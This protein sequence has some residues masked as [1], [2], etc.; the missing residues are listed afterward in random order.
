MGIS[1][2]SGVIRGDSKNRNE[3]KK[4]SCG[5]QPRCSSGPQ[6]DSDPR[7][8]SLLFSCT[9]GSLLLHPL[10]S[11]FPTHSFSSSSHPHYNHT[12]SFFILYGF[13]PHQIII[14]FYRVI[15]NWVVEFVPYHT[16][17]FSTSF[18]SYHPSM[19]MGGVINEIV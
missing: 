6:S 8:P 12:S 19:N 10:R 11:H 5:K 13:L 7:A 4:M 17:L 18:P 3:K 9:V 2:G 1:E 15:F 14:H 16:L